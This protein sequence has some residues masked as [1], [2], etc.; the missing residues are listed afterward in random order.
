MENRRIIILLIKD[1]SIEIYEK[2]I[3]RYARSMVRKNLS[4]ICSLNVASAV[5]I[6][7]AKKMELSFSPFPDVGQHSLTPSYQ[8]K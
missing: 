6:Q 5:S 3:K 7:P 2:Q 8:F 1:I 4:V